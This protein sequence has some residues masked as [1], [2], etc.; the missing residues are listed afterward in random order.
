MMHEI[1]PMTGIKYRI[2]KPMYPQVL[3]TE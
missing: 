2:I 3:V 1:Q